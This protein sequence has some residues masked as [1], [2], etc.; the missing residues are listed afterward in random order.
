[1]YTVEEWLGHDKLSTT[2]GYI[3]FAQNYYRN[4]PY[5]WIK[6]VL[7][8]NNSYEEFIGED[9]GLNLKPSENQG[10]LTEIPPVDTVDSRQVRAA[11]EKRFDLT[12][13]YTCNWKKRGKQAF[14][15]FAYH[16]SYRV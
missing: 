12:E 15:P 5:D 1:M 8:S 7:K 13:S 16:S 9:N 4:A 11:Q 3:R 14:H 6:A 10:V 2:Q